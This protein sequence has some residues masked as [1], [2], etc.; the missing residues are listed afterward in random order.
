M[1]KIHTLPFVLL[2]VALLPLCTLLSQP[3]SRQIRLNPELASNSEKWTVKENKKFLHLSRPSFGPFSTINIEKLDSPMIVSKI[4]EGTWFEYHSGSRGSGFDVRKE[5]TI[6]AKSFYQL[7]LKGTE[8]TTEA[9]FSVQSTSIEDRP[10]VVGMVFGKEND[11][12]RE[13]ADYKLDIAGLIRPGGG[14]EPWEFYIGNY[15]S[16]RGIEWG[17]IKNKSDSVYILP[18]RYGLTLANLEARYFAAFQFPGYVS[19]K[20]LVWIR[21]DQSP[22][23]QRV[24]ATLFAI[25]V[26]TR[27]LGSKN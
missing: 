8:D 12:P 25:I 2:V 21:N 6:K 16:D 14:K 18:E 11:E 4:K 7:Q 9:L 13:V 10:T 3:P 26:S 20:Y 27:D 1:K 15:R 5:V 17:F 22:A 19:A 23:L 24:I